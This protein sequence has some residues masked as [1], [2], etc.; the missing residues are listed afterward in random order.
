VLCGTYRK[1][2]DGLRKT[3]NL[4]RDSG[5]SIL[6]P[7]NAFI[8]TEKDGFVYM[9]HESTQTPNQ[10]EGRHLDAILKAEFVWLFA[11]GGYV[12]PT[13]ALEVGFAHANGIPVYSDTHLSDTTIR[14]FVEVVDSPSTVQD[15]F[16]KHAV[17]PPSPAV[18]SFQNYYRRAAVQ[19]GYAKE[20]AKDCLMLMV[21]EV[22]ELAKALRKSLKITR[23]G[24]KI[25]NQ[26]GLELAD[27]FLYV[28]HMA[29]I[30][31]IDL[32]SVVQEKEL[33]NIKKF[34]HGK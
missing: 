12:G 27:V 15:R 24:P 16:L 14:E 34:I 21:E 28:V 10:I 20:D 2:P 17:L 18:K 6:S 31:R 1:D 19:R 22:G 8:E 9:R 29:N 26:E 7:S 5:F 23:H 33:L 30:L 11:P 4:L 13:G 3:F 32:P 25:I